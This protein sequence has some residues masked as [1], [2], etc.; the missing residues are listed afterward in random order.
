MVMGFPSVD[1]LQ[2]GLFHKV[3]NFF[4]S[5]QPKVFYNTVFTNAISSSS[6]NNNFYELGLVTCFNDT[7]FNEKYVFLVEFIFL[8]LSDLQE[9]F[10]LNPAINLK[11]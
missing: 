7:V 6:S 8:K 11:A 5:L 2:L 10:P 4:I 1:P 9:R 3:H